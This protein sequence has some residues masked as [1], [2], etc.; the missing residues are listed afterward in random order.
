VIG[1]T[2]AQEAKLA[3]EA[4]L[5]FTTL[6]LVTDYDC[7]NTQAGDVEVAE[8]LRILAENTARVQRIVRAVASRLPAKRECACGSALEHAIIT[9]PALVPAR[10]R[11]AL[12]PL[13][14]RYLGGTK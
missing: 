11:R 6:A 14:G 2:N 10:L 13:V 3:R 5:C 8:I 1:M 7:W 12:A 9:D 4:E